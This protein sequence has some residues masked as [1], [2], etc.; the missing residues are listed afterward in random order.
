M[1]MK[2]KNIFLITLLFIFASSFVF[3][4]EGE[5][6]FPPHAIINA[7]YV[8]DDKMVS[9]ILAAGGVDKDIRDALGATALHVATLHANLMVVKLL[10][11]YGFD[12]NARAVKNG[13]TPLHYAVAANNIG[14]ARLLLQYYANKNIRNLEGLTPLDKARREGKDEMIRL[15]YR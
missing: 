11:D 14:A 4:D 15:L 10:L 9:D 12:P 1:N 2:M 8:G 13:N 6:A 7:S 5:N 3:S